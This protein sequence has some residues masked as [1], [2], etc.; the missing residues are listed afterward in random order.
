MEA[1][2][3]EPTTLNR[4]IS[5]LVL[6]QS[7][8]ATEDIENE[9]DGNFS[10]STTKKS[11]KDRKSKKSNGFQDPAFEAG[12]PAEE[13][14]LPTT[15]S[16]SDEPEHGQTIIPDPVPRNE[17]H[18]EAS[19]IT[20]NPGGLPEEM[21]EAHQEQP[22]D[23]W[24]SF[25]AK[26]TKKEK[27]K[28]K[29][30]SIRE[31][32][33]GT[34]LDSSVSVIDPAPLESSTASAP[35]VVPKPLEIS[36]FEVPAEELKEVESTQSGPSKREPSET[37]GEPTVPVN[38]VA[39]E[40]PSTSKKK[41]K[42]KKAK[43]VQLDVFSATPSID[44]ESTDISEK[45]LATTGTATEVQDLLRGPALAD[46]GR[47]AQNKGSEITPIAAWEEPLVSSRDQPLAPA[48]IPSEN[49][50]E[51]INNTQL[52]A[53]SSMETLSQ[54]RLPDPV[55]GLSASETASAVGVP[56]HGADSKA[57]ATTETAYEVQ[58]ILDRAEEMD[59]L[60][61][62]RKTIRSPEQAT[63]VDDF[64]WASSKKKK[65]GKRPIVGEEAAAADIQKPRDQQTEEPPEHVLDDNQQNVPVDELETKKSR[66]D[67][68]GKRKGLSRSAS[69]FE[70]PET[71]HNNP[72]A[73]EEPADAAMAMTDNAPSILEKPDQLPSLEMLMS[74]EAQEPMPSPIKPSASETASAT[75]ELE[76]S[77]TTLDMDTDPNVEVSKPSTATEESSQ[78][79]QPVE[80]MEIS[81]D[82]PSLLEKQDNPPNFEPPSPGSGMSS[83]NRAS[84]AV[85]APQ[86]DAEETEI[87]VDAP[88]VLE[89]HDESPISEL[90]LSVD[91]NHSA[92]HRQTATLGPPAD[93]SRNNNEPPLHDYAI[94][95]LEP[96]D[97]MPAL[98]EPSEY[99][100]APAL[101]VSDNK[102]L[103]ASPEE[104]S[105]EVA[106][107]GVPIMH[108]TTQ[109]EIGSSSETPAKS[110]EDKK[111]SKKSTASA[112]EDD[113][114]FAVVGSSTVPNDEQ[115][116][117][118][119]K[120]QHLTK[121]IIAEDETIETQVLPVSKNGKKKGKKAKQSAWDDDVSEAVTEDVEPLTGL[122]EAGHE[123]PSEAII[124]DTPALDQE[125][126]RSTKDKKT[127]KETKTFGWEEND[128]LSIQPTADSSQANVP[129]PE[130][131]VE[132]EVLAEPHEQSA[133]IAFETSILKK[134]KKRGKNSKFMPWDE[135]EAPVFTQDDQQQQSL[136][137]SEAN[138][139]GKDPG[140]TVEAPAEQTPEYIVEQPTQKKNKKKGKKSKF[141]D[142]DE[143]E[144]PSTTLE[145]KE[146]LLDATPS[147]S[148]PNI[149]IPSD[150]QQTELVEE[151]ADTIFEP[152]KEIKKSEKSK[153]IQ[154]FSPSSPKDDASARAPVFTETD[155]V[156]ERVGEALEGTKQ[157]EEF[158][159]SFKDPS[160]K[161]GKKKGK[162][163]KFVDWDDKPSIAPPTDEIDQQEPV[164]TVSEPI[165]EQHS[166]IQKP[167]KE[168]EAFV[169]V[170]RSS[171]SKKAKKKG[172]KSKYVDWDE[173]PSTPLPSD[174]ANQQEL[175]P[176][177]LELTLAQ[178]NEPQPAEEQKAIVLGDELAIGKKEK[179]KGRISKIVGFNNEP[180]I[181]PVTD[182]PA[183]SLSGGPQIVDRTPSD[184]PTEDVRIVQSNEDLVTRAAKSKKDKK[185]AKKA[186]ALSW[187]EQLPSAA[188]EPLLPET[189][190]PSRGLDPSAS[191]PSDE[192]TGDVSEPVPAEQIKQLT[193]TETNCLRPDSP[194]F[195]K[196]EAAENTDIL[197][198][199]SVK[200]TEATKNDEEEM[201]ARVP[202]PIL[203]PDR[204]A[205]GGP[206]TMPST[207]VI[208]VNDE[209]M[210][211]L[212]HDTADVEPHHGLEQQ[213][214]VV[215]E[216][217]PPPSDQPVQNASPLLLQA[218]DVHVGPQPPLSTEDTLEIAEASTRATPPDETDIDRWAMSDNVAKEPSESIMVSAVLEDSELAKA[219]E[220]APPPQPD[221]P[222]PELSANAPIDP[223]EPLQ[224]FQVEADDPAQEFAFVSTKD[225]KKAK[226]SKKAVALE[227]EVFV[228]VQ[229]E[230][231]TIDERVKE[232]SLTFDQPIAGPNTIP[233]EAP[234][235][236]VSISKKE[237]K[238]SKKKNKPSYFD[239]EPSESTTPVEPDPKVNA[240]AVEIAEE[241]ILPPQPTAM[242]ETGDPQHLSKKKG[243]KGKQA[244]DFL[245][246]PSPSTPQAEIDPKEDVAD[247]IVDV[248]VDVPSLPTEPSISEDFGS[249]PL[250]KKEKRKSK[251]T[252]SA[253]TFDEQ[254][255]MDIALAEPSLDDTPNVNDEQTALPI[256]PN[257]I[258]TDAGFL[259]SSK[260]GKKKST[261]SRKASIDDQEPLVKTMPT[262]SEP[263]PA[264][265]EPVLSAEPSVAVAEENFPEPT[266][267]S[268]KSKKDNQA[269]N[270]DN[271]LSE[272][273]AREEHKFDEASAE[274]MGEPA[275]SMESVIVAAEEDIPDLSK[276]GKTFG[277]GPL[278]STTSVEPII[279]KAP[280]EQIGDPSFSPEAIVDIPVDD[281]PDSSKNVK[282]SKRG[283]KAFDLDDEPSENLTLAEPEKSESDLPVDQQ[284][285]GPTESSFTETIEE[286]PAASSKKDK[287]SKK[288]KKAATINDELSDITVPAEPEGLKQDVHQPPVTAEASIAEAPEELFGSKK[289]EDKESEKNK[290][291]PTFDDEV[292]ETSTPVEPET[293]EEDLPIDL[294]PVATVASMAEALD[295]VP[296]ASGKKG[297]KSKK[298]K[299]AVAFDDE[300][301]SAPLVEPENLQRDVGADEPPLPTDT[302]LAKAT[303]EFPVAP[304]KKDK[305]SKKNKKAFVLEDEIPSETPLPE[306]VDPIT[307]GIAVL[308][309]PSAPKAV[310]DFELSSK[311]DRKKAKKGKKAFDFDEPAESIA[312]ADSNVPSKSISIDVPEDFITET[313]K[314]KKN[315]KKA[316]KAMTWDDETL[317]TSPVVEE[318]TTLDE[319]SQAAPLPSVS[320]L[321]RSEPAEI[322]PRASS[323]NLPAQSDNTNIM[324]EEQPIEE[325]PTV[326]AAPEVDKPV[327]RANPERAT[328]LEVKQ[329]DTVLTSKKSKKDK[330]AKKSQAF[331]WDDNEDTAN[332]PLPEIATSMKDV[333]APLAEI[334]EGQPLEIVSEEAGL[335][336]PP[337]VFEAPEQMRMIE[338]LAASQVVEQVR[339]PRHQDPTLATPASIDIPSAVPPPLSA[340][341]PFVQQENAGTEQVQ[342][343]V[344]QPVAS[345]VEPIE[346]QISSTARETSLPN[347]EEFTSFAPTKKSK[348]GKKGKKQVI[349]WEDETIPPSEP[350]QEPSKAAGVTDVASRPE[351]MAWPTEVRLNQTSATFNPEDQPI[352]PIDVVEDPSVSQDHYL[353]DEPQEPAPVEDDRSDYFGHE[354]SRDLPSQP[355]PFEDNSLYVPPSSAQLSSTEAGPMKI[356]R[357]SVHDDVP[358]DSSHKETDLPAS[359]AEQA[360][361]QDMTAGPVDGFEDLATTKKEKKA[362]RKKKQALDDV[363]WEFPSI[364]P[365]TEVTP[366]ESKWPSDPSR[367]DRLHIQNPPTVST[368]EPQDP[369]GSERIT[370][371]DFAAA[372]PI[373][374]AS[375]TVVDTPR[376]VGMEGEPAIPEEPRIE[377]A[378]DEDRVAVSKKAKKGKKS[379]KSKS[380][381][382]FAETE[383]DT[384]EAAKGS[385][386][387]KDPSRLDDRP[388]SPGVGTVEAI[389]AAAAVS[390]GLST[391]QGLSRKESKKDKKKKK[392]RQASS[393]WTEPVEDI[394]PRGEAAIE[395]SGLPDQVRIPT[396]ER[397]SPIQAWHQNI[398]LS[399]SPRHSELYDIED[400]QPR[401][402]ASIRRKRSHD[403]ERRQSHGAER[404]SPIQAWHHYDTPGQSPRQSELYDYDPSESR[405]AGG[406]ASTS[407]INRD[408]AVHVSDS[409][410]VSQQ[411]PVRRAMRD[412]G[413]PETEASPI[414][415]QEAEKQEDISKNTRNFGQGDRESVK[416]NP[417]QIL[418]EDTIKRRQ[419]KKRTRSRSPS[420]HENDTED[421]DLP[422]RHP[423]PGSFEDVREPSPVSSTT[424]DRS[425]V[426]FQSS[427]STREE[428]TRREEKGDAKVQG[429][430][431]G[432]G[433][434]Q[435]VDEQISHPAERSLTP[436]REDNS[437]MV[438]ARAESLA[439][440]SGLRGVSEEQGKSLFGGP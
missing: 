123:Q 15:I 266:R 133:E 7:A 386:E 362:K 297:K 390:A 171:I 203:E 411:S 275:L 382:Y 36:D 148:A 385:E 258:A 312:A 83:G 346:E 105:K 154:E 288:A 207:D 74:P 428:Q 129:I 28:R 360:Q 347:D 294:P 238:K 358:G 201:P 353:A 406:R 13:P 136:V 167:S 37:R 38:E 438:N 64:A 221:E 427:P 316:K 30:H 336:V 194:V 311:K 119:R 357:S 84:V 376:Q 10:L 354:P 259:D 262:E 166:D 51:G 46:S 373:E 41:K 374:Q 257:L 223:G 282:T 403:D 230:N 396:P 196:A 364:P 208:G 198:D 6:P 338:P 162:K 184:L 49:T 91:I 355:Q 204:G 337:S 141:V 149:E 405:V 150:T 138:D 431:V 165:V 229:S 177:E 226:K 290:K 401:S 98:Q 381:D 16:P 73:I 247:Q 391:A 315:G 155:I 439:A 307:E 70:E 121:D 269:F 379:K 178:I 188:E 87:F 43:G 101:S 388:S 389:A 89:K 5:K 118:D 380:I 324:M 189:E 356:K 239:D 249:T 281:F 182:E 205:P 117:T 12:P 14:T 58:E 254:P 206:P 102:P 398:S 419:Q 348:K 409:P 109:P 245:D 359:A 361:P 308:A 67:K 213:V 96:A 195:S 253:F 94:A 25:T 435:E 306:V 301:E 422:P 432:H 273:I 279:G 216:T 31:D 42:S 318:A 212:A 350:V 50:L 255:S 112:W 86:P 369:A 181:P 263:G 163:S 268:K 156:P 35:G 222:I 280:A 137:L 202:E 173:E 417:L 21:I 256:E 29:D 246:E 176:T 227:D 61:A 175:V 295:D 418:S 400:E 82:A 413:Y 423:R 26:M 302:N 339:A 214:H 264:I 3:I 404:R 421:L 340:K 172:K 8:A 252:K 305:K 304:S 343:P 180:S 286:K 54:E 331:K 197:A 1:S 88:S 260:K 325:A 274:R 416:A 261:K 140:F 378:M 334:Q 48:P 267:K 99:A 134:G 144:T 97:T 291:S 394:A 345:T 270:F 77:A 9:E 283:K 4:A 81:A 410:I 90:P 113:I 271:E 22:A 314:D 39:D 71:Q 399:Q 402:A 265:D 414:V 372:V 220:I 241:P 210:Q 236:S 298:N 211:D 60:R 425:S 115:G 321:E 303:E 440:L 185:N 20:D 116:F 366:V 63:E 131:E 127:S 106:E 329:S 368:N 433:F 272:N 285:P 135:E 126:L 45:S 367:G 328:D 66:K 387:V 278:E 434:H 2:N 34:D 408:S 78:L 55:E 310:D 193:A 289:D 426:L 142:F 292:L 217:V 59:T 300:V 151:A 147:E 319:P 242:E 332:H 169:P 143:E 218:D 72:S 375:G 120:V 11:K 299:K 100:G 152:P 23:E 277:D 420:R 215:E 296:T 323:P 293:R 317:E 250:T 107:I 80:E 76:V 341:E 114:P 68:K 412:S 240:V 24:P 122:V 395:D 145:N 397:R 430:P 284:L 251:K 153:F 33:K 384:Q 233:K 95:T 200:I 342:E 179:K 159:D 18:P 243:K 349:D 128:E 103:G 174:D 47:V 224:S 191:K 108:E 183:V 17:Q 209:I 190:D 437:A 365:T 344:S 363:L 92:T 322:F 157:E 235:D 371:A 320:Q 56:L 232:E 27:K 333:A 234:D 192:M 187:D 52:L 130:A 309:D 158:V 57:I 79:P 168:G 85:G 110:R 62:D 377:D 248:I 370:Q 219:Q 199:A 225:K 132:K 407:A 436:P 392:D 139:A 32:P 383:P 75:R 330:K 335:T 228:D 351:M 313:K 19:D 415:N 65:K 53:S 161:K 352:S 186:K 104:E 327:E 429:L 231:A 244:V 93:E 326:T 44:M 287:K 424:K 393:T 111:K 146:V 164:P 170:D 160:S 125:P 69:D 276:K 124:R 40:W 237:K